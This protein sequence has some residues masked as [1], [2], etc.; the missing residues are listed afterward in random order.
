MKLR[1]GFVI[2]CRLNRTI[3]VYF[4][5][6]YLFRTQEKKEFR[7]H[8]IRAHIKQ[9]QKKNNIKNATK[10]IKKCDA[11]PNRRT[12]YA[13]LFWIVVIVCVSSLRISC[14]IRLGK[15]V[16][17]YIQIFLLLLRF[18]HF[19][20]LLRFL[21]NFL[22]LFI[23]LSSNESV[24][25]EKEKTNATICFFQFLFRHIWLVLPTHNCSANLY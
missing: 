7:N 3:N 4:S 24:M 25:F 20:L 11:V 14:R 9:K 2:S 5:I 22:S 8:K 16:E 10:I 18:S 13:C 19:L 12:S 15:W 17:K 21:W 23:F 1:V 6:H